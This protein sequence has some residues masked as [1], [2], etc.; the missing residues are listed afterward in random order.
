MERIFHC[1]RE[2]RV[3]IRSVLL[4]RSILLARGV[5]KSMEMG[6][7]YSCAT[8]GLNGTQLG[9]KRLPYTRKRGYLFLI[10]TKECCGLVAALSPVL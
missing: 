3:E 4:L 2:L 5:T 10:H 9:A 1:D 8:A 6:P 7:A